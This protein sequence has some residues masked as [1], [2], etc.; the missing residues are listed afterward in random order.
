MA[1]PRIYKK[2]SRA[3]LNLPSDL[4][5][6]AAKYAFA[7]G[8]TGGLSELAARLLV[9]ELKNKKIASSYGRNLEA[10]N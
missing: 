3:N 4:K 1:R 9:A 6:A 7:L 10:G 5:K 8:L 2:V